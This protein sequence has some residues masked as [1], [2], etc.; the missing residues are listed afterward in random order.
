MYNFA[1]YPFPSVH[2]NKSAVNFA[3]KNMSL[4]INYSPFL[5]KGCTKVATIS[6]N[7]LKLIV[8]DHAIIQNSTFVIMFVWQCRSKNI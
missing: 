3:Y 8:L 5:C 1:N 7:N 6:S 4:L 2:G